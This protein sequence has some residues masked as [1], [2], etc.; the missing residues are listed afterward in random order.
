MK[1]GCCVSSYF[2]EEAAKGC[3]AVFTPLTSS[4]E[5]IAV[6]LYD[7]LGFGFGSAIGG[8]PCT[9]LRWLSTGFCVVGGL[10][11]WVEL[12]WHTGACRAV[13]VCLVFWGFFLNAVPSKIG[14]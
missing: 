1:C 13:C 10:G 9:A 7:G 8:M 12:S 3:Q 11:Y 2:R 6:G 4:A 5:S 14:H